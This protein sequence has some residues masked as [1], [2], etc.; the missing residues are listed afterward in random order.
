LPSSARSDLRAPGHLAAALLLSLAACGSGSDGVSGSTPPPGPIGYPEVGSPLAGLPAAG[1]WSWVEFPDSSCDEGTP[2]G[3]AVNPGTGPDLLVFLDGGGA[4]WDY[5]TCYSLNLA[6]HGPVGLAQFQARLQNELPGSILDRSLAGNPYADATLV[7][8]PYCTGDIHGGDKVATYTLGAD[9]RTHR[10]VGRRNLIAFLR[11]IAPTWPAP[12][13]LAVAGSS[14]GGFGS[15]I[16]YEAFRHYWPN[17]PAILIDDSGPPLGSNAA[18]AVRIAGWYDAWNLG[19]ALDPVCGSGCRSQLAALLPVLAQRYP[20][21]R[22]ALLSSLRDQ[23]ISGYYLLAG[24][25]LEQELLALASQVVAPLPNVRHFYVAG[26]THPMLDKP[27]SFTQGATL[28][29]WLGQQKRGD[30]AWVS[31]K[32]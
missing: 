1:S 12:R 15:V 6:K 7:F 10:H 22:M 25:A 30:P 28:L 21:D 11:R 16:N 8:V 19:A 23:V 14:A 3:I 24:P 32:P 4:C 20:N 13:Q 5:L 27:A 18:D 26:T 2:T 17:A 29:E 9:V 31:R